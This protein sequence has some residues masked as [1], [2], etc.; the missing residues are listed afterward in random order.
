[1]VN[2]VG[3]VISNDF[4]QLRESLA[5]WDHH[6]DQIAPGAFHGETTVGQFDR[7]QASRVQW[8]NRIRYRGRTPPDSYAVALTLDKRGNGQWLGEKVG[9][10]DL[11]LQQPDREAEF[12][13]PR[14]WDAFV[15]SI[16][17]E[18]FLRIHS[19]LSGKDGP[20]PGGLHGLA[21]LGP[22]RVAT[23]QE[24]A[25]VYCDMLEAA[26]SKHP[27]EDD[28]ETLRNVVEQIERFVVYSILVHRGGEV[29][30]PNFR[31]ERSIVRDAEAIIRSRPNEAVGIVELCEVLEIGERTLHYAFQRAVGC[32]PAAWLRTIRL[33]RVRRALRT[34][35]PY[36][37]L[38][39]S[40]AIKNGFFHL[41]RFSATYKR[42]FG[43]L[44]SETLGTKAA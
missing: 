8:G 11:L 28:L 32:S 10:D 13:A 36:G 44:P 39:K 2:A 30:P 12:I 14:A 31:R 35:D 33:N 5:G 26:C 29:A 27:T 18:R 22:K 21:R 19:A 38:I 40:V 4:D 24:Q 7:L 15:L 1:M 25:G 20:G 17:E 43:E 37:G 16:P 41:G 3:K 6:Y 42:Q 34:S 23:L 9:L